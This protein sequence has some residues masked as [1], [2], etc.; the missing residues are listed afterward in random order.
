MFG[1]NHH[2]GVMLEQGA[3]NPVQPHEIRPIAAGCSD[4]YH[5]DPTYCGRN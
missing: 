1:H 2:V 4:G 5:Y 3:E